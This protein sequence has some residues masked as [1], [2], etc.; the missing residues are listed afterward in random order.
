VA[1]VLTRTVEP[2]MMMMMKNLRN[3]LETQ[4]EKLWLRKGYGKGL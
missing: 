4:M 1:K 3:A 2:L